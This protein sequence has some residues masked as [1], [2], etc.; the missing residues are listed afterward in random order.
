MVGIHAMF[1]GLIQ[2]FGAFALRRAG[3]ELGRPAV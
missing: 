2:V 3:P 1:H